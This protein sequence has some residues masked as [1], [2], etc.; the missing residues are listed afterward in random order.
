MFTESQLIAAGGKLWEGRGTRRVYFNNLAA[1][2]GFEYETYKTGNIKLALLNGS[3]I[4]NSRGERLRNKFKF[5]KFWFESGAFHYDHFFSDEDAE[6]II[7]HI[8]ATVKAN[9]AT[10]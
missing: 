10:K 1:V 4:P 5:G 2:F 9:E 7:A 6:K 8:S 3:S